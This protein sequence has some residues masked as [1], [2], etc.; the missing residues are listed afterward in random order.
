V[1]A[2]YARAIET[3]DLRLFRSA[4]PNLS[5]AEERR[6]QEGFRAVSSQRVEITVQSIDV[7]DNQASV[8]AGRRDVIEVGGRQQTVSSQQRL[9]FARSNGGWVITEI[10]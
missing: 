1:I 6:L 9:S 8:V 5:A 10:R 4:K 3:K 7:R 2:T